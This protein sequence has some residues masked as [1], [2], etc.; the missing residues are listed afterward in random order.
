MPWMIYTRAMTNR[1]GL[2]S[3]TECT[4]SLISARHVITAAH[5]LPIE[6]MPNS[7]YTFTVVGNWGK[8]DKNNFI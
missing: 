1:T 8:D 6:V 5:C 4:A 2:N 7:S 3:I